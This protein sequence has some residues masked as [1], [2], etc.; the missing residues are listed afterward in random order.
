MKLLKKHLLSA[1]LFTLLLSGFG[2]AQSNANDTQAAIVNSLLIQQLMNN[3]N[4]QNNQNNSNADKKEK[5]VSIESEDDLRDA[6]FSRFKFDEDAE[7]N[8]VFKSKVGTESE[9]EI[10]AVSKRG[11]ISYHGT[12]F[13]DVKKGYKGNPLDSDLDSYRAIWMKVL[14]DENAKI[15]ALGE[16]HDDQY[17]EIQ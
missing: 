11:K 2:F 1:G 10:W 7:D 8:L 16:K 13:I 14:N 9:I 6:G 4:N 17:F 15:K 12:I 3:Q 5:K